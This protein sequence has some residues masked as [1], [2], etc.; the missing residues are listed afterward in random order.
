MFRQYRAPSVLAILLIG[1]PLMAAIGPRKTPSIP[2]THAEITA[3]NAHA[4]DGN[5]RS[6]DDA[7]RV[8]ANLAVYVRADAVMCDEL[9]VEGAF[10]EGHHAGGQEA[11][12]QAMRDLFIRPP[13]DCARMLS[14]QQVKLLEDPALSSGRGKQLIKVQWQG[15]KWVARSVDLSN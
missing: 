10:M 6:R 9:A 4:S 11:G 5:Q 7:V 8:L 14:R 12:F 1:I 15:M 3:A 2:V 13:S